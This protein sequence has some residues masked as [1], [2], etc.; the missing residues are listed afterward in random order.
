MCWKA[1]QSNAHRLR[2]DWADSIPHAASPKLPQ[3]LFTLSWYIY[4][5]GIC[6]PGHSWLPSLWCAVPICRDP[7]VMRAPSDLQGTAA[8][9]SQKSPCS[10]SLNV[11]KKCLS[12]LHNCAIEFT[13]LYWAGKVHSQGLGSLRMSLSLLR[14]AGRVKRPTE[15]RMV[16]DKGGSDIKVVQKANCSS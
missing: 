13:G 15:M 3:C 10:G 8:R 7:V 6:R 4:L 1:A 9:A 16:R 5:S 11:S 14:E 2:S 12:Q